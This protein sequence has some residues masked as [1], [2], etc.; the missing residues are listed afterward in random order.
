MS[1]GEINS[2]SDEYSLTSAPRQRVD[3]VDSL[4]V[5]SKTSPDL[6]PTGRRFGPATSSLLGGGYSSHS[7]DSSVFTSDDDFSVAG[8]DGD[9]NLQYS[10]STSPNLTRAVSPVARSAASERSPPRSPKSNGESISSVGKEIIFNPMLDTSRQEIVFVSDR[11][12]VEPRSAE[13]ESC[14]SE[15]DDVNSENDDVSVHS[16]LGAREG[17]ESAVSEIAD[18]PSD[19]QNLA[20]EENVTETSQENVLPHRSAPPKRRGSDGVQPLAASQRLSF[21]QAFPPTIEEESDEDIVHSMTR[22]STRELSVDL[23]EIDKTLQ[24]DSTTRDIAIRLR[25]F[26]RKKSIHESKRELLSQINLALDLADESALRGERTNSM[27]E[28]L[29]A[30]KL[31]VRKMEELA[32]QISNDSFKYNDLTRDE[33]KEDEEDEADDNTGE[34][35]AIRVKV[36]SLRVSVQQQQERIEELEEERNFNATKVSELVELMNVTSADDVHEHLR[37]KAMEL[38]NLTNGVK[39]LRRQ[40]KETTT[41]AQTL[42]EKRDESN[43]M[44]AKLSEILRRKESEGK[45]HVPADNQSPEEEKVNQG[46]VLTRDQALELTIKKLQE[47]VEFLAEERAYNRAKIETLTSSIGE[48]TDE[49]EARRE[50]IAALEKINPRHRWEPPLRCNES[51]NGPAK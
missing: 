30:S 24:S 31:R 15:D 36:L 20:D 8:D 2:F 5:D 17:Q 46:H 51:E 39:M 1:I 42:K 44:A 50:K 13:S 12:V 26:D 45:R 10:T 32:N 7:D 22:T 19:N 49:N 37:N 40:L 9:K 14:D 41:R 38:A 35:A 23:D 27:E 11:S 21:V 3:S 29:R 16:M 34:D 33:D 28:R 4:Y 43:A 48:M 25:R 47:K 6:S 18:V